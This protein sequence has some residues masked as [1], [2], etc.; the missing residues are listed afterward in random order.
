[1]TLKVYGPYKRADGRQHV[2]H[3]D[4]ETKSR[5]TQSYPRYLMELH[6]GRKLEEYEHVDHINEDP[7]DDRVEN[8]QLTSQ[9]ENNRKNSKHRRDTGQ[10]YPRWYEFVCPCCGKNAKKLYHYYL[11]NNVRQGKAGP[12]CSRSCA[13]KMH[14]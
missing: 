10:F 12:Y 11:N 3:Y 14:N 8:Y 2:I 13:G 6:L 7:T 4:N 5:T 1:M 9:Q